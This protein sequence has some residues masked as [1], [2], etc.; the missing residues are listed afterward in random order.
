MTVFKP[1]IPKMTMLT[2]SISRNFTYSCQ[3][4]N[5]SQ[6]FR[7]SEL[8]NFTKNTQSR[9]KNVQ[10]ATHFNYDFFVFPVM[11]HILK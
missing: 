5:L 4:R 9:V 3:R 8:T 11:N 7:F 10:E 2:K 1:F 6:T